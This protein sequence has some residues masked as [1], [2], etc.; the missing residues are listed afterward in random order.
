RKDGDDRRGEERRPALEH[1][2]RNYTCATAYVPLTPGHQPDVRIETPIVDDAGHQFEVR[3]DRIEEERRD[4][5]VSRHTRMKT[6]DV[7][8]GIRAASESLEEIHQDHAFAG[9][10]RADLGI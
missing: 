7:D 5:V 2:G 9:R 3:A 6:I 1:E 8:Q 10:E 4:L